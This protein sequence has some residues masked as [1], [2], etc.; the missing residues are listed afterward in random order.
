MYFC[1]QYVLI[2]FEDTQ[3]HITIRHIRLTIL[4]GESTIF[5]H[6]TYVTSVLCIKQ[7]Y[8]LL[9]KKVDVL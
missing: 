4:N 3:L 2:D 5:Q 1:M 9:C 6:V 7:E 8:T